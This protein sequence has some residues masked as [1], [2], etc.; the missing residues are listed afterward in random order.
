MTW[1][2]F[3]VR[4]ASSGVVTDFVTPCSVRSPVADT[5]IFFAV[6]RFLAER[7]RLRQ[8]ERRGREL[9]RLHDAALELVVALACGRSVTVVRSTVKSSLS[10]VVPVITILPVTLD[11]RAGRG[12]VLTEQHLVHAVAPSSPTRCSTFPRAARGAVVT[13]VPTALAVIGG[14]VDNESGGGGSASMK[15][16]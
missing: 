15:W 10:T 7:D 1:I 4:R 2:V 16:M 3:P 14:A 8:L 12:V 6:G 5:V 11:V 9:R 13:G